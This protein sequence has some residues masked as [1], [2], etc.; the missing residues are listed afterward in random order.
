MYETPLTS[1]QFRN[2]RWDIVSTWALTTCKNRRIQ[3]ALDLPFLKIW[4]AATSRSFWLEWDK[5]LGAIVVSFL[6]HELFAVLRLPSQNFRGAAHLGHLVKRENQAK[7][8]EKLIHWHTKCLSQVGKTKH[9]KAS[10]FRGRG[11]LFH[12]YFWMSLATC[13]VNNSKFDQK[14]LLSISAALISLF[15][16]TRRRLRATGK[17]LKIE[18]LHQLAIENHTGHERGMTRRK[19]QCEGP[20]L[21]NPCFSRYH[22]WDLFPK[23]NMVDK[24]AT[25]KK[26]LLRISTWWTREDLQH[27]Q[28]Q[29]YAM[30]TI[31]IQRYMIYIWYIYICKYKLYIHHIYVPDVSALNYGSMGWARLGCCD[32]MVKRGPFSV[33]VTSLASDKDKSGRQ[34]HK[35]RNDWVANPRFVSVTSRTFGPIEPKTGILAWM[36]S[37]GCV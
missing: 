8:E 9:M 4:V 26:W 32:L 19:Y 21:R 34:E 3:L 13:I 6:K 12:S 10:S 5:T 2:P 24:S 17:G 27:R 20:W 23:R 16:A 11:C 25:Q 31:S 36:K 14:N 29:C 30:T 37:G 7:R 18:Q 28:M 35:K 33:S 22:L 15:L 1:K